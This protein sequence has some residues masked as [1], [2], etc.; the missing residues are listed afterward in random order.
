MVGPD[1]T[2][3]WRASRGYY[4]IQHCKSGRRANG[5]S[6]VDIMAIIGALALIG[7]A[8]VYWVWRN[9]PRGGG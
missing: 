1:Q 3:P 6:C 2:L 7:A 4:T 9:R 5:A 8:R